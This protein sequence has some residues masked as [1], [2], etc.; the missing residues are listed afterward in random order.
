MLAAGLLAGPLFVATATLQIL[1]R[2][3]FDLRRHP[4]SL[5]SVGEQGWLQV[6]NFIV[7]GVLS[8]IFSAG[9]HDFLRSSGWDW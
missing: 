7:A 8:I 5:L 6:T 4:I 2:D 9:V 1:T 3:G